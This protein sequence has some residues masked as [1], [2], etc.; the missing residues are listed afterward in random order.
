[1]ILAPAAGELTEAEWR[2][3]V[4]RRAAQYSREAFDRELVRLV[5]WAGERRRR[6]DHMPY[7][8]A[9]TPALSEISKAS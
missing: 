9:D 8:P 4:S 7:A 2:A 6:Q 5:G 1:V 3:A